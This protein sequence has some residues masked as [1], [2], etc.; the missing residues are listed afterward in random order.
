MADW[1]AKK[2]KSCNF[3]PSISDS[4]SSLLLS[5]PSLKMADSL[6][7]LAGE[8]TVKWSLILFG[9][10]IRI[11]SS[12]KLLGCAWLSSVYNCL[13]FS[14]RSGLEINI[15]SSDYSLAF[16]SAVKAMSSSMSSYILFCFWWLIGFSGSERCWCFLLRW[17]LFYD[18]YDGGVPFKSLNLPLV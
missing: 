7:K 3:S 5:K 10:C 8:F 9:N 4:S 6:V 2:N 12:L 13:I 18:D 11:V 1:R 16:W 17:K 15:S 14:L